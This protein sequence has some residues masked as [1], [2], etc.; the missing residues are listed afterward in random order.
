MHWYTSGG[1]ATRFRLAGAA[2]S[3]DNHPC[4]PLEGRKETETMRAPHSAGPNRGALRRGDELARP[5]ANELKLPGEHIEAID[6]SHDRCVALGVSRIERPDLSPIG[7]SD[8]TVTRERNRRL[9]DHAAPVMEML[10]EQI[11]NSQS[12]VVLTDATGVVV[13]SIGDDDFLQRANKVALRPGAVWSETAKGTNAIG[14][15]LVE[16]V[17]TLVH[18]DEHYVHANQFLT[19]SAAPILDPRGNILGVLDVSGD[20]RSYHPVSYTHLTLPTKRIV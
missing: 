12:M 8:L 11:V 19:C 1:P 20:H 17:P 2:V 18:A 7:R 4:G 16:E 5:I 9:Y 15:A 6:Q 13:H 3:A 10:H 14:T